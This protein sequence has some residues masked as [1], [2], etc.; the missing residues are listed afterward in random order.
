MTYTV[1][2]ITPNTTPAAMLETQKRYREKNREAVRERVRRSRQANIAERRKYERGYGA[3]LRTTAMM[4]LGGKCETCGINDSR[5]L[6]IDHVN[7][8]G[9]KENHKI[10]ARGVARRVLAHPNDYQLLC[11]NHNWIKRFEC[12][13]NKQRIPS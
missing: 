13:E 5:V 6:Q 8:G 10:K 11:A 4:L 9:T 2:N 7:G 3:D 1:E 12:N